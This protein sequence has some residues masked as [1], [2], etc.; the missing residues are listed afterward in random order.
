MTEQSNEIP[1]IIDFEGDIQTSFE[2]LDFVEEDT[3][4]RINPALNYTVDDFG[5]DDSTCIIIEEANIKDI[6]RLNQIQLIKM[7]NFIK[8]QKEV[9]KTIFRSYTP[10]RDGIDIKNNHKKL[11]SGNPGCVTS[12][13]L[14]GYRSIV[15]YCSIDNEIYHWEENLGEFEEGSFEN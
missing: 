13:F 8:S 1:H 12:G 5:N 3:D 4:E 10:G 2:K 15:S 9:P 14:Y 7:E 11:L 6:T